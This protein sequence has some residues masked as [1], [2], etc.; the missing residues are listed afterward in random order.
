MHATS[1][2]KKLTIGVLCS[3]LLLCF[4]GKSALAL[5]PTRDLSQFNAQVWLTENG[6]PQN[7]VHSITQARD[8]YVWLA[9]EEGLARFDGINFAVFDKQNT[10]QLKSNDVRVLL[11]DRQGALW[12]GTADGLIQLRDG[13]FTAFST[14]NGLPSNVVD[15]LFQ[16]H[17][18][19]VW[20][21]TSGGMVVFRDGA[22]AAPPQ[23]EVP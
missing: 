15:T 5:D 8:G 2:R 13:K 11:A 3:F 16:D 14:Q 12:I 17:N 20:V 22:F 10:P 19:K 21:A 1:H 7:T 9:T 6:L 23:P 4:G 18:N